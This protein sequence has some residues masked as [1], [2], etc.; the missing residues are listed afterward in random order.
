MVFFDWMERKFYLER[1][2]VKAGKDG[3]KQKILNTTIVQCVYFDFQDERIP[4]TNL[5]GLSHV[6]S[7]L[8]T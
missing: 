7:L 2:K 4:I 3:T 5:T 8:A 1:K 6:K